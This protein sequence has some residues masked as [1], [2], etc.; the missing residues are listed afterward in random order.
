VATSR[1]IP[2][3]GHAKTCTVATSRYIANAP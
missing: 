3:S 1:L 2:A